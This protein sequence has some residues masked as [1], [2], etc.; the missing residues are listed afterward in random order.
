MNTQLTTPTNPFDPTALT[1]PA[2]AGDAAPDP[3]DPAS[4]RLTGDAASSLGVK[5]HLLS[6]PARKPD[7][8]WFVR[9]HPDAAYW[10]QTAVIELKEDRE[11]YLVAPALWSSLATETT[12]GPR[13]LVT[14]INRQGVVFL[15]PVRMPGA[16]GKIDEWSRTALE[17]A[18]LAKEVWVRVQA[19]MSLGAYE[20]HQATGSIPEPN[21]PTVPL[22][23]LLKAG[24]R[25]KFIDHIDHP[26]LKKL[27]GEA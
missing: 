7:K 8:A 21:W 23:D 3:F 15:W 27:R 6:V 12:F 18:R 2:G 25:E 5:K 19:N 4:L 14:A 20:V 10:L 9:T 1:P 22:K 17:A 24:F 13:A 26:V 16:D 11:T